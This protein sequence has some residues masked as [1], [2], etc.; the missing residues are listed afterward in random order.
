MTS[1]LRGGG[2]GK[3]E[4]LSDVGGWGVSE[5]SGRPVFI[6]FIKENWICAMIR[7]H[8]NKILLARNLPVDSH[9][10]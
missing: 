4:M 7:Y 2:D 9:V 5:C 6:F 8:A 3:N 10:R 1:T